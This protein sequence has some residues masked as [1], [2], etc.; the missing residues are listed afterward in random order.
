[1]QVR[2]I[3]QGKGKCECWSVGMLR[4]YN[5]SAHEGMYSFDLMLHDER[6][7]VRSRYFFLTVALIMV[8]LFHVRKDSPWPH[9]LAVEGISPAPLRHQRR[10]IASRTSLFLSS[11]SRR[12][13]SNEKTCCRE[14][15]H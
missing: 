10:T 6:S 8:P 5:S 12:R 1:M 4:L 11:K 15:M 2:R 14:N 3:A 9:Y 7:T 13:F